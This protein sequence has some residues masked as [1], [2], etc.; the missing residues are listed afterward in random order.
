MKKILLFLLAAVLVSGVDAQEKSAE[1]LFDSY[2]HDF[3]T[4]E[5]A[6]GKVSHTFTFTNTGK[7]PFVITSV[8]VSCGCTQPEF[9]KV[10]VRPGDKGTVR[11]TFDPA[12]RPGVFK[13]P[14][15]LICNTEEKS[16][17]LTLE[18]TVKGR[19]RTIEEDYLF[20]ISDGVRIE[21]LGRSMGPV[22]RGKVTRHTIG[23]ANGGKAAATIDVKSENL[24]RFIK[25]LPAKPIL[26]PG[27]RS[28]IE[29]VVDGTK[30]DE[31]GER[32][33]MF[34]PV[35]NSKVSDGTIAMSVIFV[36][37]MSNLTTEELRNAPVADFSS[38]FYHFSN[39]EKGTILTRTFDF[40]NSGK[41]DLIIR[42]LDTSGPRIKASCTK[43]ILKPGEEA[44]LTVEVETADASAGRLS[45]CVRVISND[46]AKPSREIRVMATI[47]E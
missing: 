5:E 20:E 44:V 30:T 35:A 24:P 27:E 9:S 21:S 26:E 28:S 6:G 22:P 41:R 19:P 1:A 45:E 15:Y 14:V 3:G 7:T 10:P 40:R 16:I 31:W 12:N 2:S 25:I 47:A 8:S 46:S 39:Q 36:E 13:K 18:G 37:D 17:T 23:V 33:F 32:Q 38:Y 4:I 11:L 34:L 42:H 29:I 43:T